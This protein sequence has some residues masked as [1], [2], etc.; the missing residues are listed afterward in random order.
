M[1]LKKILY[2]CPW[3][4]EQSG[5]FGRPERVGRASIGRQRI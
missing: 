5:L 3:E 1:L 4:N 2:R